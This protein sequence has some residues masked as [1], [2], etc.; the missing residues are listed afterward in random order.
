M[1]SLK[2]LRTWK[3]V[4]VMLG[5]QLLLIPT[6]VCAQ[7]SDPVQ[8][9]LMTDC[10]VHESGQVRAELVQFGTP[11]VPA[12][13]AAAQQGPDA[14]VVT[15][16]QLDLS[17]A[18]DS[19]QQVLAM[20]GPAGLNPNDV[21][22][23]KVQNRQ[24]FIAEDLQAFVLSYRIRALEG[25][26][27]LGDSAAVQALQ[28]F[29]NNSSSPDL[30]AVAK[31]TLAQIFSS[32]SAKL[33]ST[34]QTGFELN[35]KFSLAANSDGINPVIETVTIQVGTAWVMIPPGSFRLNQYGRFVFE[36]VINGVN[37]EARITPL[38]N[39]N[40]AFNAEGSGVDL[41]ALTNPIPVA[42]AIGNDQG[43]TTVSLQD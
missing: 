41:T 27:V 30:Q 13:V 2:S 14:S 4:F 15:Q 39:N 9:W 34:S 37:L 42:L 3:S 40:F 38:S 21:L 33:E 5:L 32:F 7:Q 25:L 35:A 31:E 26:G 8:D 10:E 16:R 24:D 43:L 17:D 1:E 12:L 28:Q 20:G 11:A 23:L 36:G 19:V 6:F 18:Y 22:T 29:A